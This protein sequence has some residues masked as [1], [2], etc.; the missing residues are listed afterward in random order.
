MVKQFIVHLMNGSGIKTHIVN[1]VNEMSAIFICN[2]L[3]PAMR[4]IDVKENN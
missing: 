1:C 4:V 2:G 3:F